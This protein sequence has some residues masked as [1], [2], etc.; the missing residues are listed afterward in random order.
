MRGDVFMQ[1]YGNREFPERLQRLVQL[2]LATID[3]E[4]LP[5]QGVGEIARGH[6][7]EQLIMLALAAGKRN[8]KAIKL[9][10]QFLGLCLFLR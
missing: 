10:G 3:I 9:L 7:A 2:N 8:R 5:L 4:P 1:F 6:R